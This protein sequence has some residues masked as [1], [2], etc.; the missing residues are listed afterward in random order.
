MGSGSPEVPVDDDDGDQDG[1]GVHDEG[2]E[3]VL[4]DERQHERRWR[5]DLWYEQQEDDEWEQNADAQRHLFSGLGGQIEDQD[6]EEGNEHGREN[7]VDGVEEG[8]S[9]DGDVERDVGLC[10]DWVVVHVEVSRNFDDV[11]GAGLPVVGQVD[12]VLVV[13]ER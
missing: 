2:E 12:V 5:Q 10:G 13:V 9:A 3:Q 11:P 6:A 1:D 7:Q 4:G 8:L